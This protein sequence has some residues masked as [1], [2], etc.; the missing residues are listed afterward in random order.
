MKDKFTLK[1]FD[2]GYRAR[3]VYKLLFINKKYHLIKKNNT[4]LDLGAFPG[5]WMQVCLDIGAK[6]IGIDEKQIIS[7]TGGRFILGDVYEKKT[8]EKIYSHGKYDVV[9]S[10]LAPKTTGINNQILSLDLSVQAFE[11]AK[12]VLSRNGNFLCKV[13]QGPGFNEFLQDLRKNFSF[14]KSVKPEASKKK[15]NE[16]YILCMGYKRST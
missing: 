1:A 8:L 12:K 4:V 13:F 5:S 15:S 7:M 6:V 2:E 3:S 11:I 9:L 14:V 10:D 16:M